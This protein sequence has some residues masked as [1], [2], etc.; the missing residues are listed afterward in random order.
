[1]SD[2]GDNP[3]AGGSGDVTWTLQELL[4]SP[5]FSSPE[6]KYWVYAS[7]PGAEFVDKALEAGVGAVVE[8]E[9]GAK[10]DHNHAGP[11]LLKGEITAIHEGENN[12][13]VAVKVGN[14]KVIVTRN[15]AAY[16]YIQ[17]FTDLNIDLKE[18]DVLVVKQGYLVPELY[19][20][21]QDWVMALTPGGVD[22]DLHR[23]EYKNIQRPIFPLDKDIK[24]D[25][26]AVFIPLSDQ[27]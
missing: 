8:G 10:V 4:K 22:Q 2:M 6:G 7:I 17:Q 12:T 26:E 1:M 24:P 16:H 3:T 5:T 25:L 13:S 15:R 19:E 14:S 20:I 9:V 18:A 27:N 21:R 23:L 11:V